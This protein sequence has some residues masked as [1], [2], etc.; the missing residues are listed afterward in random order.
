MPSRGRCEVGLAGEEGCGLARG[1]RSWVGVVWSCGPEVGGCRRAAARAVL[2]CERKVLWCL[3]PSSCGLCP[4]LPPSTRTEVFPPSL[5][6]DVVD[7][8]SRDEGRRRLRNQGRDMPSLYIPRLSL[9]SADMS[10]F[11]TL[12]SRPS[13]H[14]PS[15]NI[16]LIKVIIRIAYN[17]GLKKCESEQDPDEDMGGSKILLFNPN[18]PYPCSLP[19]TFNP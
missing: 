2:A 14:P 13:T 5:G 7:V 3:V 16:F 18:I 4:H 11:A 19:S 9:P 10:K 1:S 15:R 17:T 8:H 12:S 6:E